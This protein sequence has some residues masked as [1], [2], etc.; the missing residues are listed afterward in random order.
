MS[1]VVVM[2]TLKR[3]EFLALALES[4]DRAEQAPD[5]VR[6]YIDFDDRYKIADQVE[7][8]RDK[9]LPR[10]TIYQAKAHV[11]APSGCWNILNSMKGGYESGADLIFFI[12]EDVRVYHDYFKWS[13]EAQRSG[14]FA[15]SGRFIKRYGENYYTNP[16]ASFRRGS[17]ALVVPH[18]NDDFFSD[19]RAYLTRTFGAFE[20]ASDL[21]DGLIRHVM[22]SV[23]GFVEHPDTPKVVHQGFHMYG[24]AEQWRTTGGIQDRI[25]QLREMLNRLD[26]LQQGLRDFEPFLDEE[27]I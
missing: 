17:L 3:P 9:Y 5:D 15:T 25:T 14:C 26:P 7:Y 23:N 11:K 24:K 6:I 22:C 10:A 19:R 12:E 8:V 21:D 16:G 27:Y 1:N 20:G 4:I 2:P 18:I 13:I